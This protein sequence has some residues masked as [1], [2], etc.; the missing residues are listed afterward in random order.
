MRL[1]FKG[2]I[3]A[4]RTELHRIDATDISCS[5]SCILN[6]ADVGPLTNL[7]CVFNLNEKYNLIVEGLSIKSFMHR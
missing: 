6:N 3:T 2:L 1:G 5:T 7:C 4:R